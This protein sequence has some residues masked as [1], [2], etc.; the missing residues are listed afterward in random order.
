MYTRTYSDDHHGILIPDSYGGT[1]FTDGL[2]FEQTPPEE[3][4]SDTRQEETEDVSATP[5]TAKKASTSFDESKSHLFSFLPNIF[6]F[7]NFSLQN[8]GKEEVL[9]IAAAIFL[10]LSKEGDKELAIML[11]LLLFLG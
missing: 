11:I 1:T 4:E 3:K 8:L 9:I 7:S 5:T 6:N 10:F 2:K